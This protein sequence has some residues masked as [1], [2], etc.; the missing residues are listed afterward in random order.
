ML[1]EGEAP[2]PA[3]TPAVPR[4]SRVMALAIHMQKLVDRGEVAGYSDLGRLGYVTRSRITQ[5]M[6]LVRL[7]P[8]IQEELL[9]LP[10][11]SAGDGAIY[12]R[13]V[14]PV[15]AIYDWRKQRKMWEDVKKRAKSGPGC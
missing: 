14:C 11:S 13:T 3:A 6:R 7:A 12:E 10:C 4:I 15:A 5:I 8:D 9:F 1:K 2:K